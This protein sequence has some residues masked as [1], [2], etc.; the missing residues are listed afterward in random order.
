MKIII[1]LYDI[2]KTV[3]FQTHIFFSTIT[4]Q[5]LFHFRGPRRLLFNDVLLAQEITKELI[6]LCMDFEVAFR[7]ENVKLRGGI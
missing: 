7:L 3:S 5:L 4:L 6:L 1:A 2:R